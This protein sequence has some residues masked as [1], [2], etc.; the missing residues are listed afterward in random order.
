MILGVNMMKKMKVGDKIVCMD[1]KDNYN[2]LLKINSIYT[3]DEV[4]YALD[5]ESIHLSEIS[6]IFFSKRFATLKMTRKMKL[7]KIN[8]L[9]EI[10]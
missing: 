7:D 8:K 2:K 5:E 4:F 9:N 10:W 6:G 3:I 1:V